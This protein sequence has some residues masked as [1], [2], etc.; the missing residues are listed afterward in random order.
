MK[1]IVSRLNTLGTASLTNKELAVLL[2]GDKT[3]ESVL[4]FYNGDLKKIA[5]AYPSDFFKVPG[6][7]KSKAAKISA[8]FELGRR[9]QSQES[10]EK[11]FMRSSGDI[12]AFVSSIIGDSP[13]EVFA[14]LFL[15]RSNKIV[16]W[17]VI[18]TGGITGTVA[19]P[20]II[21]KLAL[22]HS[23]VYVVLAHNHPSGSLKPS[24]ADEEL[25]Q[26]IKEAARY[27]DVAVLDHIIVSDH[28]YYSFAD[29]GIL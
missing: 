2:L 13:H 17:Q 1:E 3:A 21:L 9:K 14:C 18:S 10:C 29:E 26:K 16:N 4:S 27:I 22:N 11:P 28:G 8:L 24:R 7:T 15:N 5:G 20:R 23:A 19:D 12:A 25:T 6:V